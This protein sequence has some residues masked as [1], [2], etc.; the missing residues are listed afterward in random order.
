MLEM[1]GGIADAAQERII[2]GAS[3]LVI[4]KMASSGI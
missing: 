4:S 1:L 3:H 2:P